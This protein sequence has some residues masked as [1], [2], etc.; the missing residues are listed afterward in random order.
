MKNVIKIYVSSGNSLSEDK[1]QVESFIAEFSDLL[2]KNYDIRLEILTCENT[3][4]YKKLIPTSDLLVFLFSKEN[5]EQMG[6]EVNYAGDIFENEV[7]RKTFVFCKDDYTNYADVAT[8]NRVF[9]NI[10]S[11]IDE[12]KFRI[13]CAVKYRFMEYLDIEQ[14]DEKLLVEGKELLNIENLSEFKNYEKFTNIKNEYEKIKKEFNGIF[15]C[16]EKN[17]IS[18]KLIE[19]QQELKKRKDFLKRQVRTKHHAIFEMAL[20]LMKIQIDGNSFFSLFMVHQGI[21]EGNYE[22]A[23]N[24]LNSETLKDCY[25][26]DIQFDG[27]NKELAE[28]ILQEYIYNTIAAVSVLPVERNFSVLDPDIVALFEEVLPLALTTIHGAEFV[29]CCIEWAYNIGSFDKAISVFNDFCKKPFWKKIPTKQ[30]VEFYRVMANVYWRKNNRE[31]A[32]K[33]FIKQLLTFKALK[34]KSLVYFPK[35]GFSFLELGEFYC[36]TNNPKATDY[37]KAAEGILK[38]LSQKNPE[39]FVPFVA[40]TKVKLG[41]STGMKTYFDQALESAKKYPE[42]PICLQIIAKYG[43]GV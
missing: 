43:L 38:E 1:K 36:D 16:L 35:F 23:Y 5:D 8:I 32:E 25:R 22:D 2:E 41:K 39:R 14:R 40:Y 15:E 11:G 30:K 37:L 12:I 27:D 29:F 17:G 28:K 34:D 9:V 31:E 13:I 33:Y 42:N 4:D 19:K 20:N 24:Y 7:R 21:L 26:M 18:Q 10:Y 6:D 3:N